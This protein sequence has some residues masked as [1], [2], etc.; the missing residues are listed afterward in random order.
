MVARDQADTAMLL[1][2]LSSLGFGADD[3]PDLPSRGPVHRPVSSNGSDP[4][5]KKRKGIFGR[6]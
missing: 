5:A 2:E 6:G 1:R 4:K 3:E